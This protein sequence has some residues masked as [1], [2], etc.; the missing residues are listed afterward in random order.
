MN[1]IGIAQTIAGLRKLLKR[2]KKMLHHNGQILLDSCDV[3]YLEEA[4]IYTHYIGEVTYHT[5]LK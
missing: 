3:S 2:F 1:G 5:K 4:N